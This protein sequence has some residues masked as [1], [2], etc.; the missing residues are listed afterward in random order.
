M[1]TRILALTFLLL[2]ATLSRHPISGLGISPGQRIF[3]IMHSS[4]AHASFLDAYESYNDFLHGR[5]W[6]PGQWFIALHFYSTYGANVDMYTLCN[7]Q[8]RFILDVYRTAQGIDG[9]PVMQGRMEWPCFEVA[10][11]SK[12]TSKQGHLR[13]RELLIIRFYS[14]L[15]GWN[16]G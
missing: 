10:A 3:R 6:F 16:L 11:F 14:K 13:A 9:C 1:H 12:F 2:H 7:T 5:S 4:W 15:H 8:D